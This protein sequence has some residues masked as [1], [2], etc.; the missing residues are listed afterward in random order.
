[1]KTALLILA[2]KNPAQLERLCR[3]LRHPQTNIFVHLDAK[4]DI[5]LFA[6]AAQQGAVF[7]GNRVKVRWA[8]YSMVE[9][10]LASMREISASGL[11]YD[12]LHLL[13]GQDYPVMAPEDIIRE[14]EAA[15]GKNFIAYR[16][17]DETDPAD[18]SIA[19]RYRRWHLETGS[20]TVRRAV[21]AAGS[22]LC[23]GRKPP[24]NPVYK[25]SQW[26]TVTR[27]AVGY[28]LRYCGENPGYC[29]FFR[30]VHCPDEM[31]FQNI[32]L[33]SPLAA[34]AVNDNKRYIE[35]VE[36]EPGPRLLTPSDLPGIV[37]SGAWFARK[38]DEDAPV[39]DLLD[40][41]IRH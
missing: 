18:G 14:L 8:G 12:Y 30:H 16:A 3:V 31:F 22:L 25:G 1:M 23:A 27:E 32:I 39:L 21:K 36:G 6:G 19:A 41:R 24:V 9:A 34:T 11:R 10:T 15:G 13:S 35:W 40:D 7:I 26:F 28:I 38:F 17:V 33:H 4:A 20:R 5:S 2:H 37:C 29:G